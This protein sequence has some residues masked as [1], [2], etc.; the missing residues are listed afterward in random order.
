MVTGLFEE[1]GLPLSEATLSYASLDRVESA[2]LTSSLRE[3]Q[4]VA[5]I[6]GRELEIAAETIVLQAA[7]RSLSA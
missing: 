4:P 6:H 7:Y 3:I 2:F 1:H 5:A